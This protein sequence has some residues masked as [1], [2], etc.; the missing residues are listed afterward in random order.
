MAGGPGRPA[1]AR[2]AG[3]GPAGA[4]RRPP[5]PSPAARL[6]RHSADRLRAGDASSGVRLA[7]GPSPQRAPRVGPRRAGLERDGIWKGIGPAGRGRDDRL[8]DGFPADPGG[9]RPGR[10]SRRRQRRERCSG[11]RERRRRLRERAGRHRRRDVRAGRDPHGRRH[12]RPLR[13][14]R[15]GER[16]ECGRRDR[17]HRRQRGAAR[18]D[19]PGAPHPPGGHDDELPPGHVRGR[20]GARGPAD[21][22]A[23]HAAARDAPREPHARRSARARARRRRRRGAGSVR[24][25]V[26]RASGAAGDAAARRRG[27]AAVPSR[28]ASR[29]APRLHAPGV[30]R[31]GARAP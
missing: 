20:A 12:P 24:L 23:D 29:G 1:R 14:R 15:V 30:G 31:G 18:V 3:R 8:A 28:P 27:R 17:G 22:A 2:D 11:R 25:D 4:P 7:H 13:A 5:R 26:R 9:A 10:G 19:A 16:H 21:R 6:L